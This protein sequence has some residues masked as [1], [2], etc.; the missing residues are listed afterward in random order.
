MEDP[1]KE[2]V[3]DPKPPPLTLAQ[4]LGLFDP[5][6]LPLSADEWARVKQRSV[7]QGDSTQPCPICRE[8]FG[9]HPQVLLSCS[10]VFHR[11][12]P[13]PNPGDLRWGPTLQ[14]QVCDQDPGVLA[15]TRGQEVVPGPEE[16]GAA[17]RCQAEEEVL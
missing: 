3:L 2:Y 16:D 11:K 14:N 13:V 10:H 9:L 1:E 4:K 15:R 5:P 8:E 12:E 6:P 17:H 7:E